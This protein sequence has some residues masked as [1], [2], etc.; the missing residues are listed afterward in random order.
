M[1]LKDYLAKRGMTLTALALKLGRPISTVHSWVTGERRPN[2][3]HV[4]EIERVTGG[5]VRAKDFV[6]T[7]DKV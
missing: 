6:P 5:S 1:T 2:W 7:K 3:A 4:A